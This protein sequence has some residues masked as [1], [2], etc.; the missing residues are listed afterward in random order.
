MRQARNVCICPTYAVYIVFIED[1]ICGLVVR[2]PEV[3]GS[4]PD[5]TRFSEKY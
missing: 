3:P 1:S 5:D 2:V 4:I